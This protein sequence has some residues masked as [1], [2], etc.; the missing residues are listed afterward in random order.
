MG[1]M[2]YADADRQREYMRNWM[3]QRR[4]DWL[5]E[6]GPCVDCGSG[7]DLEVDHVDASTKITHRVWSWARE[8][9]EAELAKCVV[10]CEACHDRKTTASREH[11]SGERHPATHLTVEDVWA[12][13]TSDDTERVLARRY[14]LANSTVHRIRAGQSWKYLVA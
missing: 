7:N 11:V 12:I 5:M 13:R 9:R 3:R 8:R 6:H 14:G 4:L 2:P 10:R 1:S